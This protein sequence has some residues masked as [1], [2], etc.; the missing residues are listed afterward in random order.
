MVVVDQLSLLYDNAG[1]IIGFAATIIGV[2]AKQMKNHSWNTDKI[3]TITKYINE[4]HN[5]I[6]ANHDRFVSLVNAST[7]LD[8]ALKTQLEAHGADVDKIVADSEQ[9]K[10]ALKK[11]LDEL[12]N[13]TGNVGVTSKK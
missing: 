1:I 5:A 9:G 7:D 3:D 13:L 6:V 8:P 10:A 11:I 4:A 2:V 12:N